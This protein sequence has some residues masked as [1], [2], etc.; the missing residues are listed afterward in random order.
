MKINFALVGLAA[1][2]SGEGKDYEYDYPAASEDRWEFSNGVTFTDFNGKTTNE[3][4]ATDY[5]K[6][7]KLSCWNSNMIRDMNN[8]NKFSRYT[9][10]GNV[11]ESGQT[12]WKYAVGD[13]DTGMNHQYGFETEVINEFP[14]GTRNSANVRIDANDAQ[15]GQRVSATDYTKWGYNSVGVNR[16]ESQ[17]YARD[18]VAYHFGHADNHDN[19][20][21]RPYGYSAKDDATNNMP[22]DFNG[23]KDDWRFSLRMGGCLYEANEW[24]Y[25]ENSFA[26]TGR[27]TYTGDNQFYA[28]LFD[29]GSTA[30]PSAGS[31]F[32]DV[33]WV[34]VFNAHI[35]PWRQTGYRQ[36]TSNNNDSITSTS[37]IDKRGFEKTERAVEDFN[38]VMAN[39]TYEGHGFLNFVATYHDHVDMS[40]ES[41]GDQP[42]SGYRFW[43]TIN[44]FNNVD[45][46]T[47]TGA[48]CSGLRGDRIDGVRAGDERC[49]SAIYENFGD[50]YFRPA[51]T[52]SYGAQQKN[53]WAFVMPHAMSS[54]AL[55]APNTDSTNGADDDAGG[56]SRG[57]SIS[58]FPH[59]E[60]GQDFRF[61][62]RTLHNM[63]LGVAQTKRV[64]TN[65]GAPVVLANAGAVWS[66]YFYAVDTIKIAFPEYV[67]RVNHCHLSSQENHAACAAPGGDGTTRN[68]HSGWSKIIIDGT[69]MK[70]TETGNDSRYVD[71]NTQYGFTQV[72]FKL[73]F[74]ISLKENLLIVLFSNSRMMIRPALHCHTLTLTSRHTMPDLPV[75]TKEKATVTAANVL[76]RSTLAS[77][78]QALLLRMENH[79]NHALRGAVQ[80]VT[81]VHR[82]VAVS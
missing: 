33:H 52:Y 20:A 65:A 57:F 67:A 73:K 43:S 13:L 21:N 80:P 36:N 23:F 61:N 74:N 51:Q 59:N 78:R 14:V 37:G 24:I 63:G 62:I 29:N 72:S 8:D 55:W 69:T 64:T 35:F 54:G 32:A 60:L 17:G 26:K 50:W 38:V 70:R 25:D 45:Q 40:L 44:G 30:Y 4:S 34:H 39:P 12:N 5:N 49:G 3:F 46:V 15:F 68:D 41:G 58:S 76:L 11:V 75:V 56:F 6:A 2:Q 7:L 16:A 10:T 81:L 71:A 31:Y 77:E 48:S 82:F 53:Y 28:N 9:Y 19:K 47:A 42:Y 27:L 22:T 66:Y 79:T 1:A 18:A